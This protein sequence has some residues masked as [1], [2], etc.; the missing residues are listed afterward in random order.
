MSFGLEP[1]MEAAK[2]KTI[3]FKT[4]PAT[5]RKELATYIQQIAKLDGELA[6]LAK[7]TEK[8][9]GFELQS[10]PAKKMNEKQLLDMYTENPKGIYILALANNIEVIGCSYV[11]PGKHKASAHVSW[12]IIKSEFKRTGS[13]ELLMVETKKQ[14]KKEKYRHLT[15]SVSARNT[16]AIAMY[17]KNNFSNIDHFMGAHLY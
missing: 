4:I 12:F 10:E 6:D 2:E 9:S 17:T 3:T 11:I 7:E 14:A 5:K 15:L 16:P 8:K 1:G 13:G